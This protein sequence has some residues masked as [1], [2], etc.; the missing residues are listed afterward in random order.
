MQALK[1]Y[2]YK[3]YSP[4]TLT[5]NKKLS[6]NL[7]WKIYQTV[8]NYFRVLAVAAFQPVFLKSIQHHG[9]SPVSSDDL[10]DRV[11]ANH[12]FILPKFL[13]V[14]YQKINTRVPRHLKLKNKFYASNKVLIKIHYLS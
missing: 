10:F 11:F 9:E 3:L 13:I 7:R 12:R 14:F 5:N 1:I 6:V 4:K 2:K 8:T